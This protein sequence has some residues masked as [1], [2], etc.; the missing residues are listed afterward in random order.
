MSQITTWDEFPALEYVPNVFR[1][2]VCGEKV[3]M[4]K[5]TYKGQVTIP[6]H[7]HEAEQIMLV[8][9]GS[10]GFAQDRLMCL[11]PTLDP[12]CGEVIEGL[13]AGDGMI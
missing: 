5:I 12:D 13:I 9:A 10:F 8:I 11:W 2:A 6:L 7:K 3:M 1:Q 4:T